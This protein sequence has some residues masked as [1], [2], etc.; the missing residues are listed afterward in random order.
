MDHNQP[1]KVM[2][3]AIEEFQ[4]FLLAHPEAGQELADTNLI[5]NQAQ[6]DRWHV[7]QGPK[8]LQS[9]YGQ[10]SLGDIN[11]AL[12]HLNDP[13]DRN[14]PVKFMLL[15]FEEFQMFLLTHP[16]AGQELADTNL[17]Y[18]QAQHDRWNVHQ[19]P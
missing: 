15:A 3:L 9:L 19:G 11:T 17:I 2:L 18:H 7:H 12:L 13:M 14:Q 6:Q 8:P 1:V 5:Y 16:K 4:M 10:P